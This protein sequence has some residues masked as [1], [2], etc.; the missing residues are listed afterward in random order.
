MKDITLS[1]V[2]F[3]VGCRLFPLVAHSNQP[4]QFCVRPTTQLSRN[5]NLTTIYFDLLVTYIKVLKMLEL[6]EERVVIVA[7]YTAA[8]SVSRDMDKDH[9]ATRT[10]K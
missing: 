1:I 4:D 3:K 6:V 2:D 7:M 8:C 9:T 10:N 5:R